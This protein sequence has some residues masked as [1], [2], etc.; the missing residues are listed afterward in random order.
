MTSIKQTQFIWKMKGGRTLSPKVDAGF[1]YTRRAAKTADV[2][3]DEVVSVPQ[4][5]IR[6]LGLVFVYVQETDIEKE[7]GR[8]RT[9][10]PVRV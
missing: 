8:F 3:P 9:V 10:D 6:R 5:R 1:N 7:D 4:A 2:E